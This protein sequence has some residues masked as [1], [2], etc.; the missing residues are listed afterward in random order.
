MAHFAQI[1]ENNA[2]T[3]VVVVNNEVLNNEP[4]P[5]SEPLGIEFLQSL[6][7]SG[8]SWKQTSYSGGF[9]K[10]YAGIGMTYN[11]VADEFVAAG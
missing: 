6:Y 3:Q 9:R 11:A 2:V 8:N 7:G 4:F 5:A 1:D 10:L